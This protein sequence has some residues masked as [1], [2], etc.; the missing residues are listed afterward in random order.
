MIDETEQQFVEKA[1]KV[2]ELSAYFESFKKFL[3][4]S[5]N[6][7]KELCLILGLTNVDTVI[8]DL[9]S[10]RY[11]V[12][13]KLDDTSSDVASFILRVDIGYEALRTLAESVLCISISTCRLERSFSTMNRAMT[14]LRNRM[15]QEMLQACVKISTEGDEDP[16]ESFIDDVIK[17]YAVKKPR[18]ISLISRVCHQ[19]LHPW[20]SS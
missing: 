3:V 17:R 10:F 14:K 13:N 8:A 12:S 16:T 9:H 2:I 6:D 18:H 19:F 4:F 5:D 11:V 7:C 15:G 20:G 1:I